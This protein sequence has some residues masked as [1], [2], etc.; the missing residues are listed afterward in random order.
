MSELLSEY[1]PQLKEVRDLASRFRKYESTKIREVLDCWA[2]RRPVEAPLDMISDF[3]VGVKYIKESMEL[4]LSY[5]RDREW[6]GAIVRVVGEYGSGKTQLGH[7]LLRAMRKEEEVVPRFISLDPISD[8][9]D[10]LMGE[11]EIKDK[12]VVLIVDEVDQL[13]RDL[14]KGRR[15]K[16]EDLA[17]VVRAITEGSYSHPPMGSVVLLLS[18]RAQ[19]ALMMDRALANR[20]IERSRQFRLSLSDEEREKMSVEA[21]KKVLALWM[22]YPPRSDSLIEGVFLALYPLMINA[23]KDLARTREIGGIVKNLVDLSEDVLNNV[24][25]D[26]LLLSKVEEGKIIE[27]LLREFLSNEMRNI[28]F[29][30]RLGEDVLDYLAIFSP[31]KPSAEGAMADGQYLVWT[32]DASSGKKGEVLVNRIAVEAKFGDY[33]MDNRDQLLRLL[34]KMPVLLIAITEA[35]PEEVAEVEAEL[36]AGGRSFA[37]VR[38]EPNLFRVAYLLRPERTLAF[39]RERSSFERDLPESLSQLMIPQVVMMEVG[40][41]E[42]VSGDKLLRQAA[43]SI[44]SSLFRELRR[45]KSSKRV[46]T[47]AKVIAASVDSVYKGAKIP[48]PGVSTQTIDLILSVLVREKLGTLSPSKKTFTLSREAPILLNDLETDEKRRRNVELVIYDI[49][50]KGDKGET[51]HP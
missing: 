41:G 32:Y 47:L 12:P 24:R 40:E 28:P 51:L 49:L 46:S 9:K 48:S 29:K 20:L 50:S 2:D 30:V 27:K 31:D 44:L 5:L 18:K 17:D 15:D 1:W 22:A 4:I 38:A 10:R 8:V 26:A 21:A 13:L 37:A 45:A 14:E 35:D 3:F 42:G 23:A 43:S 6:R 7:L 33:W 39:L 16:V 19:E 25:E 36:R 11:L 34:Q